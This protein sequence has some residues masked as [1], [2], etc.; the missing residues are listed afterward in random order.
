VDT[1]LDLLNLRNLL[2]VFLVFVPLEHLFPLHEGR[3]LFRR[4]RLL[5][6][7]HYLVSGLLIRFGMVAILIGTISLSAAVVPESWSAAAAGLRLWLQ[8]ICVLVIADLGFY[9][10]H[11]LF[12]AVPW[13]WR[14]HAIHHSI[15]EMDWL[16]A[17]RVHPVDQIL[18][19]SA[20]LV[21]VFALGFSEVA[22]G[23]SALIY[24]WQSLLIHANLRVPFGPLRWL[25]ASPEFHHWHHAN[26]REAFDKNFS[27]Q[28]PLWDMVFGTLHMP[29]GRMVVPSGVGPRATSRAAKAASTIATSCSST[30]SAAATSS[31]WGARPSRCMIARSVLRRLDS[32]RRAFRVDGAPTMRRFASA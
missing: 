14:F 22:I 17:H 21:P 26:Q 15:E 2:L 28:L 25:V 31:R 23:I 20:S 7:T 18:T 11:R 8:V 27:G 29:R 19:K 3:S 13:L 16:A 4:A 12:H 32:T 30:D 24:H 1:L 6:L 10:A 5:D 9:A